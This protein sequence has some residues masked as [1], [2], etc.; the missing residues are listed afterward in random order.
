MADSKN[1]PNRRDVLSTIAIAGAATALG[2]LAA[3]AFA[4]ARSLV[5]IS[6]ESTQEGKDAFQKIVDDFAADTGVDVN[7]SFMD[8]EGHKTAIRNYLVTAAPDICFW[9][10][11]ER[12]RAFVQRGLFD[13]ISDLV[14]KEDYAK[15]LGGALSA[16]TVNGKQYGLPLGGRLYGNYYLADVIK[17]NGLTMPK[18]WDELITYG[19]AA[20]TAGLVPITIGTKEI[21]P[22]AGFFDS[23]DLRINGLD[24]HMAL[25]AGEVSY[26][27]PSVAA[28]FDHWQELIERKFFLPDST[29]YTFSEAAALLGRHK[30]GF[31]NIGSYVEKEIP[32]DQQSNLH[33]APFPKIADVP[34]F[35]D[36]TVDSIHIPAN[37]KHKDV[38]REFLAYFYQPQNLGLYNEAKAYVPARTDLPPSKD[39]LIN[40]QVESLKSVAG[41]AQFFDR[42]TNPDMAQEAM[43]GFQ[44]FMVFPDRREQILARL[45]KTRMRVYK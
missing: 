2:G 7:L 29:S 5:I 44:E 6:N 41:T 45:E 43:K 40:E 21:W 37:A 1:H 28:V 20:K 25:C 22:V 42:D 8:H 11:G 27:D 31:M 4:Q 34:R 17:D 10:S 9:Y 38:G 33:L 13:D 12:M 32:E 39:P 24:R 26:L 15:P 18:T 23:L 19:E 14:E 16:V 30:A 35:E 36:F 3:P